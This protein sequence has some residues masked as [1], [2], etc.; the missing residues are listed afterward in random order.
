MITANLD[1]FEHVFGH[2][3]DIPFDRQIIDDIIRNRK[4]LENELFVDR[5]LKALGI[6]K[7]NLTPKG[8]YAKID[9]CFQASSYYPPHSEPELREL[10][11]RISSTRAPDNQ[12]Q[13]LLYYIRKDFPN[14]DHQAAEELTQKFYLPE[15]YKILIDGLWLIDRLKF[16][17]AI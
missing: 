1:R 17:V 7:G 16:E 2:E 6:D 11:K 14:C 9:Q 4:V 8:N 13:S 10:H 15:K 3:A 5:L 12:K